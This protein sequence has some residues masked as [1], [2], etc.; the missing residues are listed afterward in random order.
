M[1]IDFHDLP[2]TF[3]I[4]TEYRMRLGNLPK[5]SFRDCSRLSLYLLKP[6]TS[7]IVAESE[8]IGHRGVIVD[9]SG[10]QIDVSVKPEDACGSCKAKGICAVGDGGERIISVMSEVPGM[11]EVGEEVE[12]ST[13]RI[14]GIKAVICAYVYPLFIMLVL[15]LALLEA[16]TSETVAGLSAIGGVVLYYLALLFFFRRRL[17]K[18]IIF[19]I[20]K[21]YE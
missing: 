12:V 2:S 20:H 8:E 14:M 3:T 18:T 10:R 11:F 6:K 19:K 4:F 1:E 21:I 5:T 7:D 9:I 17:E 13:S 15:L 16:G